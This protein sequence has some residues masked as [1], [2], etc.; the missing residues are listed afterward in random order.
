MNWHLA[1]RTWSVPT[2][3][4][5]GWLATGSDADAQ[6]RPGAGTDATSESLAPAS[7]DDQVLGS[8]LERSTY[9]RAVLRRNRSIESAKQAWQAALGR[10]RQ[11]GSLEDPMV[12]L[13]IAPLSIG[14]QSAR[15]G[16]TAMVSQHLPWPGKLALDESVA[17]A[18]AVRWSQWQSNGPRSDHLSVGIRRATA[19]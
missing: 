12:N 13:E 5:M 11:A 19:V 18:E 2:I 6:T 8:V 14:S 4:V 3:L 7:A 10:A 17:R 15:L 9:V 1:G 16:W